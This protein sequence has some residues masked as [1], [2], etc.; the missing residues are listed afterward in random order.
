MAL[1]QSVLAYHPIDRVRRNHGLEH[2][3]IHVLTGRKRRS[4]A[5]YSDAGGFTLMGDLKTEEI[6]SGVEEALR[7]MRGGER[8]LAVHPNCGTNFVTAGAFAGLAAFAA[9]LGARNWRDKLARLPFVFALATAALIFAQPVGMRI[10]AAVTTS[11]VVGDLK[12]VSVKKMADSPVVLHRI[13]T[14]G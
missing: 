8:N 11:G 4:M 6:A 12:I 9:L 2:A 1:L 13:E 10:Q 5:G 3:T 7:R 14:E